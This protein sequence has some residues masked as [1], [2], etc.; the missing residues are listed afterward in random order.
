[1]I[2]SIN[3]YDDTTSTYYTF[4][5]TRKTNRR[6]QKRWYHSEFYDTE[7]V[8]WLFL[9][10]QSNQTNHYINWNSEFFDI[11]YLYNQTVR[12]LGETVTIYF[13]QSVKFIIM[14]TKRNILL[15]VLVVWI[16]ILYKKFSFIQQTS[17]IR[18][19][20]R[21]KSVWKR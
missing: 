20:G 14:N 1:M 13:H 7:H 5:T 6:L 4:V 15:P 17:W 19:I 21:L 3:I 11:P 16:L 8:C 12:I 9:S 10:I 18:Y 2:T